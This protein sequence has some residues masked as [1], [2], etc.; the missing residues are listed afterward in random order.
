MS[1][2]PALALLEHAARMLAVAGSQR[3]A[4]QLRDV[5]LKFADLLDAADDRLAELDARTHGLSDS[6]ADR[7]LRRAVAQL[8]PTP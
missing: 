4:D 6:P 2:T 5:R 3:A 8:R 7:A 1:T